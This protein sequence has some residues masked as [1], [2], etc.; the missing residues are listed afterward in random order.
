MKIRA[1]GDGR[2]R[3]VGG[4]DPLRDEFI[5]SIHNMRDFNEDENFYDFEYDGEYITYT[6]PEDDVVPDSGDP[7]VI[8]G[9]AE[10][11]FSYKV[12]VNGEPGSLSELFVG[13]L[14][15]VTATIANSSS[16]IGTINAID[17]YPT[18]PYVLNILGLSDAIGTPIYPG[19]SV[20]II[21][22]M[23]VQGTFLPG[24]YAYNP[25]FH[26]SSPEDDCGI[27][28]ADMDLS[29]RVNEDEKDPKDPK[30]S[31][32]SNLLQLTVKNY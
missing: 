24:V 16:Q 25:T 4:Y 3:V 19:Q 22:I 18:P 21:F 6:D 32:R 10:F 9:C 28:T 31:K 1:N 13:D 23:Q 2:V 11:D 5:I 12:R 30:R 26:F 29:I 27:Q 8:F 14:I 20:E 7:D 15:E 17:F